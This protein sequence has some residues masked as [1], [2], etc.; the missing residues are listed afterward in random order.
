MTQTLNNGQ[1]MPVVGYGTYGMSEQDI[2]D[3][4]DQGYRHIDT[5]STYNN[6]HIVGAAIANTSVPRSELF[7]TTKMST[8]CQREY[9]VEA[10]FETS[11]KILG[12][13][14]VDMY[15][16]HWP[17]V[18]KY[19]DTWK[20]LEKIYA[21]GRAKSIGVS[22]CQIYHLEAILEAASIVPALNQIELHPYMAQEELLAFCATHDIKVQGWSP[23]ASGQS[24]LLAD[25]VITALAQKYGKS[26]AQVVLRW[27][28]QRGASVI[29]RSVGVEQMQ[30][31]LASLNFELDTADIASITALNKNLRTGPDPDNFNF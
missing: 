5:A 15:L 20:T 24:N 14:Y 1:K 31:N 19:V 16:L 30:Q 7:I 4:I 13:D 18:D 27:S 12:T 22:N 23:L 8:G 3:A 11:L 29:P 26:P 10:E 28:T 21:S 2:L 6:E 17:V 9:T 25:P